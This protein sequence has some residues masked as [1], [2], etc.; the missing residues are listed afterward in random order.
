MDGFKFEDYLAILYEKLGY[1]V[2][3]KITFPIL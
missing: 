3:S 1:K 2:N